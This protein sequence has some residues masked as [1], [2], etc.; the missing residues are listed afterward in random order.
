MTE[1]IEKLFQAVDA[2]REKMDE[3]LDYIWKHPETGYR[4]WK[5]TADLEKEY[6]QLGYQLVRAGNIPGFITNLDTGRPGP[7]VLVMAE[8]DSLLCADHP[9]ADPETGAVHACGH[10]AQAAALLGVAACLKIPGA[11]DGLSGRIRLCMVPA[12]ELLELSYR[13]E[14]RQKGIIRY[15]GG[16]QEFLWRGLFDG[17]DMCFMIHQYASD[18]CDFFLNWGGNGCIVK[19]VE[20]HGVAAHAGG[21]PDQGI[22]ALYAA[23]LGLN[24]IYALRETFRDDD[25]IRVHPIITRG[26]DAVNAIPN[27]VRLESYIR[28]GSL[29]AMKQ[30]NRKVNRALCG[31]AA[32]M[33]ANIS[34]H[35]R[36]GYTPVCVDPTMYDAMKQAIECVVPDERIDCSNEWSSAC[37]DMGDM[38][39]V[40]P[41]AYAHVAGC[42]GQGHG[43]D[44]YVENKERAVYNSAKAQLAMLELLLED[45]A[46]LAKE[47]LAKARVPFTKEQ[48]FAEMDSQIL[49]RS[50]AVSYENAGKACL[51]FADD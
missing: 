11:L 46:R 19:N 37:T 2:N 29:K 18:T 4:E 7:T 35:D 20:Y 16:K 21:C 27:A 12:E 23:N 15:F 14:L 22:N 17:V 43:N 45:D 30:A 8:L 40:M 47:V 38:S 24:A 13:E 34:I 31:T 9:A 36:P 6:E 51:D 42:I 41:I 48:Y 50:A 25:H 26:G 3:A 32:A 33:G 44:Y 5:T 10:C 39:A 1:K 49:D 28:G